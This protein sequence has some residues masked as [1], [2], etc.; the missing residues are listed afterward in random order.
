MHRLRDQRS[1][2]VPLHAQ[3]QELGQVPSL[4]ARCLDAVRVLHH[5]DD[6][7]E[8]H[9][10]HD[11]GSAQSPFTYV[12][13][14]GVTG[15]SGPLAPSLP[16]LPLVTAKGS[17]ER[18][19][20]PSRLGENAFLCNSQ[21]KICKSVKS[22]T[23]V[24]KTPLQQFFCLE[25]G[26]PCTRGPDF[27]HPIATP[28]IVPRGGSKPRSNRPLVRVYSGVCVDASGAASHAARRRRETARQAFP[29]VLRVLR[30]ATRG[31][32]SAYSERLVASQCRYGGVDVRSPTAFAT[33]IR[34]LLYEFDRRLPNA[35]SRALG[36]T[37]YWKAIV[38][39]LLLLLLLLRLNF[40]FARSC[41]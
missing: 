35:L 25:L 6:C 18:Y 29:F 38:S 24:H 23:Y 34:I 32:I 1:P 40:R 8:H 22:F 17:G 9:H 37:F 36:R 39:L 16:P 41:E 14:N 28:L 5:G 7:H 26:G 13:V 10:S 20:S 3:E 33:I 11:E 4:E 21:P 30:E 19:S 2:G 15:N 12:I 27:A 31:E